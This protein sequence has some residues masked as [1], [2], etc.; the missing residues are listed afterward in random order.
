MYIKNSARAI[1]INNK[2]QILCL[3]MKGQDESF[4][5]FPGGGQEPGESLVEALYRVCKE[6]LGVEIVIHDLGF[7]M[8]YIGKSGKDP[9]QHLVFFMFFCT[10]KDG[11]EPSLGS[12]PDEIQAGWEWLDLS[13]IDEYN[14]RPKIMPK[15]IHANRDE[16]DPVYLGSVE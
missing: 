15:M 12:N 13:R 1:I 4:Y 2:N 14:I 6:E 5:T 7:V 3:K 9:N 8:D 10:L 11:S 16:I